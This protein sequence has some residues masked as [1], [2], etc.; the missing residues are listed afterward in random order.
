MAERN[1]NIVMWSHYA[2]EHKGIC[3]AFRTDIEA[4]FFADAL[5]VVYDDKYPSLNLREIVENPDLRKA[6]PWMLTKSTNWGYEREWRILEFQA[7]PGPRTFPAHCLSAVFLGCR[8]P[9][10][11]RE[12]VMQWVS[13]FPSNLSVHQAHPSP[14]D[15]CLTFERIR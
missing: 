9:D 7:G 3:L 10:H 2:D 6:A 14:T 12:K 5:P 15:F 4:T 1:D 11:G 13:A 8:I